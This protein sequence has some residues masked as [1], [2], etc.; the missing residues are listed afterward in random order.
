[1]RARVLDQPFIAVAGGHVENVD[2]DHRDDRPIWTVDI[3]HGK[4]RVGERDIRFD[5]A[6]PIVG[7]RRLRRGSNGLRLACDPRA[8]C[9]YLYMSR[10]A[11]FVAAKAPH[12][13]GPRRNQMQRRS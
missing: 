13:G 12:L 6:D 4:E 8:A 2:R 11:V 9:R 3:A 1:M 5:E 10:A 7:E